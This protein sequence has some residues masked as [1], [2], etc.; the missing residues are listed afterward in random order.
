MPVLGGSENNVF[1]ADSAN[2]CWSMLLYGYQEKD[3]TTHTSM[4]HANVLPDVEPLLHGGGAGT[5][6]QQGRVRF[7]FQALALAE[8]MLNSRCL[9]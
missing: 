3:S 2:C 6:F 7:C 9:P 5:G 1:D 4:V 8:R